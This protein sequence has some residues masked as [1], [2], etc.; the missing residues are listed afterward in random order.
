[1]AHPGLELDIGKELPGFRL[2]VS[3]EEQEGIHV[4]FGPSGAG[5]SLTLLCIAGFMKPDRG[6]IS[7][8][9]QGVFN[10]EKGLDVQPQAR[11]VGLVPQ[12]YALFPHM[13]VFQNLAYGLRGANRRERVRDMMAFLRISRLE[14]QL[15]SR[16]S[17]GQQQRVALGRALLSD[18]S[19]L[20]LDEPL[21]A[22]D[23]NVRE[24]L[25][26][27]LYNINQRFRIPILFVTHDVAEAFIMGHRISVMDEGRVIE[28]GDIEEVFSKPQRRTTAR[29]LGVKNIFPAR[30]LEA[31]G[32]EMI[33]ETPKFRVKMRRDGRFEGGSEAHLCIKPMD[34]RLVV[35]DKPRENLF[36]AKV[37]KLIPNE[38]LW[39]VFCQLEGSSADFD[40][41]MDLEAR[42][43]QQWKV[44]VGERVRVAM[45]PDRLFLCR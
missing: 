22:L 19:V 17:G 34:V 1:M 31:G 30:V 4:L 33:V 14:G 16:L 5:K 11:R 9:G 15:P 8:N 12:D 42:A 20:L 35:S 45:S 41:I 26:E 23:H 32:E 44:R 24:K 36:A 38:G 25:R 40:L 7:I 13:N 28:S 2:E 21:S 6:R 3:L 43:C 10:G 39:R 27:D 37:V 18:P 29:F